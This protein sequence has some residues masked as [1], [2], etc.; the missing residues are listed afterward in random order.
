MKNFGII[1]LLLA[2]LCAVA[3]LARRQKL[4]YPVLLVG[5]GLLLGM[6]PGV[7]IIRIH[8]DVVFLL[9]LPL[10]LYD[11]SATI[12]W[13]DLKRH[14]RQIS[15][16]AVGLVLAT[17]G[18]VAALAHW[19]LPGVG[20]P[21]AFVLG[22]V[23]AP[24]DA[25]AA[26]G[27]TQGL[28][29]PKRITAVLEGESLINDASALIVFRY[30]LGAALS[31]TFA[32][33]EAGW[34]FAWL[35]V[36]SLALGYAGS[37]LHQRI[38]DP[39]ITTVLTLLLP[40]GAYLVGEHLELSGVLTVVT[41]GL[42]VAWRAHRIYPVRARLQKDEFWKVISFVLNGLVFLLIGLQ[43]PA[44]LQARAMAAYAWSDLLRYGLL[45]SAAVIA[46]RF[47]W[48]FGL[49]F[50]SY[51]IRRWRGIRQPRAGRQRREQLVLAWAGMRGVVSLATVL[52]LPRT[53]PNG[54]PFPQ[55]LL[56][57]ALTFFVLVFTLLVQGSTLPWLVRW[58]R[59]AQP[60]TK[61]PAAERR[62]RQ[63]LAQRSLHFID[64]KLADET[65]AWLVQHLR[66]VFAR[67]CPLEVA[68]AAPAA[69]AAAAPS[70]FFQ[71]TLREHLHVM[72]AQQAHLADLRQR[73]AFGEESI[74]HLEQELDIVVLAL[75][76]QTAALGR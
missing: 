59:L 26:A 74:R 42:F 55:L 32:L 39:T 51:H 36:G 8:P 71:Q 57:V 6:V 24:P 67:P 9:F 25:V 23:L 21:V 76:L 52:T 72:R 69:P 38:S 44:I 31:G 2:L 17:V 4:P 1:V 54:Q 28:G 3:V 30:A 53:L 27:A 12:S 40:F 46:A 43:L 58:L 45:L 37:W 41:T 15:L 34:H 70:G 60:I 49:G 63:A 48:V 35:S 50:V 11:A 33:W 73:D 5:A 16:L 22:A 61:G 13:H 75:E 62:L 47:A 65:P 7:P 64:E 66:E 18:A 20:W 56:V 29:L 19:L 10:L 68:V 14:R